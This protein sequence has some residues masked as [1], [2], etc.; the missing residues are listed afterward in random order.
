MKKLDWDILVNNLT[1]TSSEVEEKELA[2]WIA[3]K[4]ENQTL[5]E[6]IRRLWSVSL[7]TGRRHDAERALTLVLSRIQQP[8]TPKEATI[9]SIPTSQPAKRPFRFVSTAYAWRI[10][11]VLVLLVGAFVVYRLFV[12]G[13]GPEKASVTFT[14]MQT[15][16]LPDG[17]KATFDVGS[18]FTYPKTFGGSGGREVSLTGEAYFEVA[19]DEKRPFILH[20][21][22]G[23]IE[24]LGTKFNI[25]AWETDRHITVAV[26]EGKVSFQSETNRN[27]RNVVYLTEDSQSSLIRGATPSP[28]EL[29]DFARTLSWMKKEIYFR[30]APVPEV[31]HQLERWYGVTIQSSDSTFL[32]S[33]I[34]IFIENKPLI[35]NLNLISVTMNLRHEQAGN[36][37]RFLPN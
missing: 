28:P 27:K 37:I 12:S 17:T 14:S 26:K 24:V 20:A 35:D 29:I 5:Y 16:L 2:A 7:Q 32:N 8:E 19:K 15:L 25:R 11:A 6:R 21:D 9:A 3:E 23:R 1:G 30:N 36:T 34:T 4:S 10:A 22:G 13:P 18:S 33:N 31:L